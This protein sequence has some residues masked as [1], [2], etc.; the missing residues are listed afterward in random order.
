MTTKLPADVE[1][2]ILDRFKESEDVNDIILELCES[3][4]LDWNE[5]ETL[6]MNLRSRHADDITISQSPILILI[7]LALF[8]GGFGLAVYTVT[9]LSATYTAF[10]AID[11]SNP[12]NTQASALGIF[13]MYLL[14]NAQEIFWGLA[15]STAMIV[16]SL[17][18]MSE[19]WSAIFAKLGWF[20][21]EV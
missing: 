15:I 11:T 10:L 16:G 6:V 14:G 5:A 8:L 12:S 21:R 19:V 2:K 1:Q 20:Q 17:K 3:R 4:G 13:I 7:A 9:N 18:G